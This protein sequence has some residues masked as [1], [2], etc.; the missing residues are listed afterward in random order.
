MDTKESTLRPRWLYRLL[1][2]GPPAI[3]IVLEWTHPTTFP[4]QLA[5]VEW[6]TLL[7]LLQLPLFALLALSVYLLMG[8]YRDGFARLSQIAMGVFVVFYTALDAIAGVAGGVLIDY[9][10][11]LPVEQQVGAQKAIEFLL[12]SPTLGWIEQLGRAG[13]GIG[14]LAAALAVYRSENLWVPPLLL[15]LSALTFG[16]SHAPPY[17]SVGLIYLFLA[18][19]WLEFVPK[20]KEPLPTPS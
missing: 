3:L 2:L 19:S 13:W 4:T 1:L 16:L 8:N 20:E 10:R 12:T 18:A 6:W 15:A 9:A 7:H 17:G 14:L 11:Q 5:S